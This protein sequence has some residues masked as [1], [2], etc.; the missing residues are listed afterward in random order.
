MIV[1]IETV[2]FQIIHRSR[3]ALVKE[4]DSLFEEEVSS[5]CMKAKLNP[6]LLPTMPN[7]MR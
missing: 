3:P 7:T 6:I 1:L 5:K 2:L 4:E